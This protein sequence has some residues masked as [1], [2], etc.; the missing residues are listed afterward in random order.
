MTNRIFHIA[1]QRRALCQ[2]NS[3]GNKKI[4][5]TAHI[6]EPFISEITVFFESIYSSRLARRT[7]RT[8]GIGQKEKKRVYLA[9]PKADWG[10][11]WPSLALSWAE[12]DGFCKLLSRKHGVCLSEN[13]VEQK[14]VTIAQ[15]HLQTVAMFFV[16]ITSPG[17]VEGVLVLR[18][19]VLSCQ[20]CGVRWRFYRFSPPYH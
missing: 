15:L 3:F 17:L 11:T 4:R 6:G 8:Q 9:Q 20:A 5:S 19:W 12:Q 16:D 18:L 1:K 10:Q 13:T 2:L 14:K 7:A